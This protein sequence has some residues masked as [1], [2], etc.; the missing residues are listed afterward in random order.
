MIQ[1]EWYC[2]KMVIQAYLH[3]GF[4]QYFWLN[5]YHLNDSIYICNCCNQAL[6]FKQKSNHKVSCD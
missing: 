2:L 3:V 1:F 5:V 6:F 4:S